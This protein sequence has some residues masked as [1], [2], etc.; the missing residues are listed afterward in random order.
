MWT[1]GTCEEGMYK[2]VK[3]PTSGEW[4]SAGREST[5]PPIKTVTH[6]LKGY[7]QLHMN[8]GDTIAVGILD[9]GAHFSIISREFYQHLQAEQPLR[10][11]T[12]PSVETASGVK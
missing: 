12:H 9:T 8:I 6:Q 7:N 4:G 10:T 1:G 5:T 2:I 3:L 11:P